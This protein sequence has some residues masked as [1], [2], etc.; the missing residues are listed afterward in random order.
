MSSNLLKKYAYVSLLMK[1]LSYLPGIKALN[2]SLKS[3]GCLHDFVIYATPDIYDNEESRRQ[4]QQ[5]CDVVKRINYVECDCTIITSN[6]EELYASWKNESMTKW[7]CLKDQSYS[8]ILFLDLDTI[9]L[10]NIDSIFEMDAPAGVFSS[11]YS[12]PYKYSTNGTIRNPYIDLQHGDKIP[13]DYI[14]EGFGGINPLTKEVMVA[15]LQNSIILTAS[16][17]LLEPNVKLYEKMISLVELVRKNKS[18]FSSPKCYSLADEQMITFIHLNLDSNNRPTNSTWRYIDQSYNITP[19]FEKHKT[20]M[21]NFLPLKY[22]SASIYHYFGN[23][24]YKPW[25]KDAK[26]GYADTRIWNRYYNIPILKK[27]SK[28]SKYVTIE[29]M[30]EQLYKNI[31]HEIAILEKKINMKDIKKMILR[32]LFIVLAEKKTVKADPVFLVGKEETPNADSQWLKDCDTFSSDNSGERLLSTLK[33]EFKRAAAKIK[34]YKSNIDNILPDMEVVVKDGKL[35]YNDRF[36]LDVK[37][38]GVKNQESQDKLCKLYALHL[39]YDY[40]GLDTLGLARKYSDIPEY[41]SPSKAIEAFGSIFNRYYDH[42]YTAFPD[43]EA[44]FGSKGSFFDLTAEKLKLYPALPIHINPPFDET[45]FN[46]VKDKVDQLISSSAKNKFIFTLPDWE[47][48]RII[49]ELRSACL[50]STVEYP[51]GTLLFLNSATGEEIAPCGILEFN[52][53]FANFKK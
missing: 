20:G 6:Q 35:S 47:D 29:L 16:C 40:L 22:E 2:N 7:E 17:V 21:N 24:D 37:G 27:D 1:G 9:V 26:E 51:K 10:K 36:F 50:K 34:H 52:Y 30:R 43:L 19:W 5:Y 11:P 33:T 46:M 12:Y 48:H 41:N 44:E 53:S 13:L 15:N 8:K 45:I 14:I 3:H 39:R 49:K 32:Y 38:L 31:L 25:N 18:T 28:P 4:I 42:F 23:K